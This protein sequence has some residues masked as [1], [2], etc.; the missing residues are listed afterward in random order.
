M[1]M[2][3]SVFSDA[4]APSSGSYWRKSVIAGAASHA[5]SSSLPSI[6]IGPFRRAA[7]ATGAWSC[8]RSVTTAFGAGACANDTDAPVTSVANVMAATHESEKRLIIL[9]RGDLVSGKSV[10]DSHCHQ[11]V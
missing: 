5:A 8:G 4:G 7:T 10:F 3:T 6:W 9:G 11:N 1:R 2:C